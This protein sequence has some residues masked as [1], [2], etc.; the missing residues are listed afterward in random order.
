MSFEK[1]K[2]YLKSKNFEDR[3]IAFEGESSTVE[4]ASQIIGCTKGEIAK[5]LSF[6]VGEQPIIVVVAGDSKISNSKYKQ[7]FGVKAKMIAF[8]DVENI[9]GHAV[10]GVCPFG[11][12]EN[13]KIYLDETL[14]KYKIVYPACGDNH[15]AVKLAPEEFET[16]VKVEKWVDVCVL[17]E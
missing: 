7:E 4:Q 9:I 15:S 1:A 11:V 12:K 14:K 5:S 16:L 3:I 13:I 17:P 10:G 2:E 8:D 6:M